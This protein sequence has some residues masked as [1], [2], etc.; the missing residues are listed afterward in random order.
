MATN[1]GPSSTQD[2]VVKGHFM[3]PDAE[4]LAGDESGPSSTAGYG[5]TAG[6]STDS[7]QY[8]IKPD[9]SPN[10]GKPEE[11]NI[12]ASEENLSAKYK[13]GEGAPAWNAGAGEG[14]YNGK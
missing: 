2:N 11:L 7:V 4:N 5:T 10:S 8:S 6:Q 13:N 14:Q 1:Q 12:S 3:L 9:T